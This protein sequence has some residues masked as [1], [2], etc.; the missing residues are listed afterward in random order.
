[1]PPPKDPVLYAEWLRKNKESHKGQN[2]GGTMPPR[3][4]EWR[5]KQREIHLGK[6]ASNA[7]KQKMSEQ[8][9]GIP[10]SEETKKK[11]S[12]SAKGRP[13]TKE[14]RIKLSRWRKGKC[15]MSKETLE[16]MSKLHSGSGNP[17]WKGGKSFEPYCPKFNDEFR[18]RVRAFFS[19]Q[20]IE[21]GSPQNGVRLDVHHVNFNKM[22]CCDDTIPLFVPLCK[23]CHARI[24]KSLED[25][26]QH[27]TDMIEQYY[28]GKC[29]FSQ[30]E[31]ASFKAKGI[32]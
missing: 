10:K 27:F 24:K 26:E 23:S 8:R 32:S 31:F 18:N 4:E 3:S 22:S 2:L 16:R 11:M 12:E 6:K 30:E 14:A 9:K 21:C 13:K 15:T 28:R 5:R 25:W 20:C 29:Y 17:A 1:M 7:T 19:Y